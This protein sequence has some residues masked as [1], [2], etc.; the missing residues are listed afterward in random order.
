MERHVDWAFLDDNQIKNRRRKG[1]EWT[2]AVDRDAFLFRVFVNCDLNFDVR[3]LIPCSHSVRL[4]SNAVAKGLI[5][6]PILPQEFD[7]RN[8]LIWTCAAKPSL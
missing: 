8:G 3:L 4:Q 1:R 7:Y 5:Q 2:G 6:R